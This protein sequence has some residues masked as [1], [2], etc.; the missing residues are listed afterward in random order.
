VLSATSEKNR[1]LLCA[2]SLVALTEKKAVL[3]VPAQYLD[4]FNRNAAKV[5]KIFLAATGVRY[6]VSFEEKNG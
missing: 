4:K 1:A 6:Q 2:A 5:Q 3:A